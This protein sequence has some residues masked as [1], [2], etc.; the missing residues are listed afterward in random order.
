MNMRDKHLSLA[1]FLI[2][3]MLAF[4]SGC[5][6]SEKV[7]LSAVDFTLKDINPASST[8]NQE[9]TYSQTRDK[10]IIIYFVSFS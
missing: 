1:P 10:V 3:L 5:S 4:S 9:R 8:F 2:A 7:D 6:K